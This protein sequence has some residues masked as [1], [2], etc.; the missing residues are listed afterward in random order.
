MANHPSALKRERQSV[1]KRDR[2]RS[3]ISSI[4]TAV[5]KVQ[6]AISEK[7]TDA[8]KTSFHH[9]TSILD[10]AASK[11]VIPNKRASRKISRLAEKV[12]TVLSTPVAS[13]KEKESE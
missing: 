12:N 10:R 11:G 6:Q 7:D 5:K 9:A 2:N 4:R 13:P 3:V 8:V 1:K